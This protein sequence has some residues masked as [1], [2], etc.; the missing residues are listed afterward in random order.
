MVDAFNEIKLNIVNI[1]VIKGLRDGINVP[2]ITHRNLTNVGNARERS[3]IQAV[4]ITCDK[5]KIEGKD[6]EFV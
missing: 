5:R 2:R 3:S 4:E 1:V 6:N